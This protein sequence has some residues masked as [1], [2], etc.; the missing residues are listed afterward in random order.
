MSDM[1]TSQVVALCVAGFIYGLTKTGILGLAVLVIPLL[2]HLFKPSE[3]IGLALPMLILA[4]MMA[5]I[6]FRKT[7]NWRVTALAMPATITGILIGWWVVGYTMQLPGQ[8]GDVMLRRLIAG[9]MFIVLVAGVAFRYA[10]S[11]VGGVSVGD[12]SDVRYPLLSRR[13]FLMNCIC[14]IAG[15]STMISNYSGPAWVVYLMNY[16]LDKKFFIGTVAWLLF[17]VNIFKLPLV[18]Q[19]GLVN[20]GSLSANAFMIPFL[21]LGAVCGKLIVSR[22][23]QGLFDNL[24]QGLALIGVLH[25]LVTS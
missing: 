25:L 16:R 1:A 4:D 8:E 22:I 21:V 11:R 23:S 19:L 2:L 12:G 10:R 3:A 9:F 6:L 18:I 7:V 13:S 5:V 14:T 17:F 15:F 24:I 20:L